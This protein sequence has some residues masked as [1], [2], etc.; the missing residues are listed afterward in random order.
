VVPLV[1]E[2]PINGERVGLSRSL[3]ADALVLPNLL[4]E[5]KTRRPRPTFEAA[6]AGYAITFESEYAVPVDRPLLRLARSKPSSLSQLS[7]EQSQ[8]AARAI[9]KHVYEWMRSTKPPITQL[10]LTQARRLA[11]S[12]RDNAPYTPFKAKW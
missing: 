7:S 2:F 6:L 10:I 4:V 9:W 1:T 3:R 8:D 12:I 5:L 11:R